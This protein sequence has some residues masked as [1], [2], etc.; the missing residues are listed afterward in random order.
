MALT[1][2]QIT[3]ITEKKFIPKLIDNVYKSNPILARLTRPDKILLLDGGEKI[4]QPIISSKPNTENKG[5]FNDLDTLSTDRTD[6]IS[7][8]EFAWKQIQEPIRISRLDMLKNSG[9]ASKLKLVM[10]KMKIGEKNIKENIG[11]GLFS[12]G[13]EFG[14]KILTGFA[15]MISESSTYGGIA[16]A[17]LA[18]WAAK[19]SDNSGTARPVTLALMQAV[20]GDCTEESDHPTLLTSSQLIQ[21]QVWSLYQPTQRLMNQEMGKLGFTNVLE[22][23]GVPLIVDSHNAAGEI[24]FLNEDYVQL[25]VHRDENLRSET[26]ERMETSASMLSRI[27]WAGNVVCSNRRFQGKLDDLSYAS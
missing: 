2:G 11:Y 20:F 14:A 24:L 13:T 18:D 16:V 9:D 23:N 25:A 22:F 8:A 27:F 19:V 17:D 21:N 12:D 7:A 6:N 3:A 15:A 10:S 1:Y 5:Y 26:I 4:I